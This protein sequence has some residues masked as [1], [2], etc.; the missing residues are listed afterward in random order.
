MCTNRVSN[1]ESCE[2]FVQK[3]LKAELEYFQ[4]P[5]EVHIFMILQ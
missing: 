5:T 4:G 2:R 1:A 3:S